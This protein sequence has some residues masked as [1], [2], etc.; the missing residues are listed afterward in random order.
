AVRLDHGARRCLERS[1]GEPVTEAQQIGLDDDFSRRLGVLREIPFENGG[2]GLC[3]DH[4]TSV[5]LRAKRIPLPIGT[6]TESTRSSRSTCSRNASSSWRW[7]ST[8]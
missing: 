8:L 6:T 5:F 2:S 3:G 4:G 7:L 1:V